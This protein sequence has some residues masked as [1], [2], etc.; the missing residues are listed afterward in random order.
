MTATIACWKIINV[1]DHVGHSCQS[2][3][4]WSFLD[5]SQVLFGPFEYRGFGYIEGDNRY[6][7]SMGAQLSDG[8]IDIP[9]QGYRPHLLQD[10]LEVS[11]SE[12]ALP[13]PFSVVSIKYLKVF[14][15]PFVIL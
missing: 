9:L 2:L 8:I 5:S 15:S 14:G 1:L 10:L 11:D 13:I 4:Q 6:S 3:L 12:S 7:E